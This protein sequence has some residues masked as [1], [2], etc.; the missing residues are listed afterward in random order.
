LILLLVVGLFNLM[1]HYTL[2]KIERG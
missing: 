2:L 1:A